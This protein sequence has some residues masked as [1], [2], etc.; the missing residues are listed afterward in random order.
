[1]EGLTLAPWMGFAVS[2]ACCAF[3][4]REATTSGMWPDKHV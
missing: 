2:L 1:M 3:R 4:G